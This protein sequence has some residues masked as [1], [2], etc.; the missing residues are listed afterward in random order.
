MAD[1]GRNVQLTTR[2]GLAAIL[3]AVFCAPAAGQAES[4]IAFTYQGELLKAGL[5]VDGP[6]DL[7]FTLFD[8][9]DGGRPLGPSLFASDV[10]ITGGLFVVDLFFEQIDDSPQGWLEVT[11]DEM[12]L[13]PR[14]RVFGSTDEP[15]IVERRR[16]M[17]GLPH[18]D[19]NDPN[20]PE[21]PKVL[22]DQTAAA[23]RAPDAINPP[24]PGLPGPAGRIGAAGPMGP[25][26]P[27]GPKGPAG[28]AGT[29]SEDDR[30][31]G[32]ARSDAVG[33][34]LN[35]SKIYYTA[36]FVGIGRSS[37]SYPLHV[38]ESDA[39][40]LAYFYNSK[41]SGTTYGSYFRVK[42][43]AG[44]AVY[45]YATASSGTNYGGYFRT[46]STSGRAV[47]GYASASSGTNYAVYGRTTS[48]AGYAGYF[49]GGRVYIE[50][51][52]GLGTTNPQNTID[53]ASGGI[54]FA[55]DSTQTT[56]FAEGAV[57]AAELAQMGAA[58]GE[59]LGWNGSA[60]APAVPA[61]SNLW[62]DGG[63]GDVYYD[64]GDVGIGTDTPAVQLSVTDTSTGYTMLSTN[65]DTGTSSSAGGFSS[66]GGLGLTA[67]SLLNSGTTYGLYALAQSNS[68][69]AGYF[70][71]NAHVTGTLSKSAGSFKIDH[72]LEPAEKYLSHSFVESPDM[73]NIYNGNVT[74]DELGEAWVTL[75]DWFE[76]LNKDLRYQLTVI[77]QFAQAI[78]ATEVE[79][80]RFSIRTDKPMVRV[81]WQVTGIRHDRYAEAHPIRVEEDKPADEKARYL[82]PELYGATRSEGIGYLPPPTTESGKDGGS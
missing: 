45:G 61:G 69:Y 59:Y 6:M 74:T 5:P 56:A 22:A 44:R 62:V 18:D 47:Y 11:V 29:S 40:R 33:W 13:T 19:P 53:I 64:S 81:S 63:G 23:Q 20:D 7:E 16:G 80:N 73:M 39:A 37:P 12:V 17:S 71:G 41:S 57:G 28:P 1:R 42:S 14:H 68:G 76:A 49:K 3:F 66:A 4:G 58:S 70:F 82:H 60:W 78:V 34:K 8:A 52:L 35:G 10:L 32:S 55:D 36:G 50:G 65:D 26:G 27:R 38:Q 30:R 25:I 43:T 48:A 67:Y 24:L 72:P 21:T 46:L 31:G 2:R 77:G 79:G 75:P 51:R 15:V 9:P 54:Q